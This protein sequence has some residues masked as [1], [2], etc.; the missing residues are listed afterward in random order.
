MRHY[1]SF[2]VIFQKNWTFL[3]IVKFAFFSSKLNNLSLN[4]GLMLTKTSLIVFIIF[5]GQLGYIV[6]SDS[7]K[8]Q[9]KNKKI[10]AFFW[11]W[12]VKKYFSHQPVLVR[13]GFLNRGPFAEMESTI[14]P[15]PLVRLNN[16]AMAS[17]L[18]TI[19][20]EKNILL[21]FS[22]PGDVVRFQHASMWEVNPHSA[23]IDFS[24]HILMYK[25]GSRTVRVKILIVIVDP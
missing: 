12:K 9:N 7:E 24:R 20:V 22:V 8:N 15:L 21:S 1:S 13:N 11:S 25:D 16:S 2:F 14:R 4:F 10:Y 17:L 6:M 3:K 23:G 19:K 18:Y 5:V